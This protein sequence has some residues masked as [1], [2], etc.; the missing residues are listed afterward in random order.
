[1]SGDADV[2]SKNCQNAG[3]EVQKFSLGA[4][5]DY[6]SLPNL[7]ETMRTTRYS[8]VDEI[9]EMPLLTLERVLGRRIQTHA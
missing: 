9:M 5:T 1:M 2:L 7:V 8:L 3:I 4:S 6:Y